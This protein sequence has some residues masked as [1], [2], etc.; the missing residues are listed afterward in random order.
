MLCR[1]EGCESEANRKGAELCEKHYARIRRYGTHKSVF[2]RSP[3]RTLQS[4]GYVLVKAKG[5]PRSLGLG[6]AYEHRVVYQDARGAGPFPCNWCGVAVTWDDM[7]IDH[8]DDDKTNNAV[9]NLVAS[10]QLCNQARGK[11]KRIE[12]M[13]AK[14]GVEF[15][16]ERLTLGE[17]AAR[18]GISDVSLKWRLANGWP[19]G[20]ALTENR[21]THGPPSKKLAKISE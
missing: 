5:H 13:R 12:T 20:R 17:W 18:L 11:Q 6:R 2:E 19:L 10:C 8:V 7:H 21:G 1:I 14:H 3:D 4:A 16:G 15:N 9:S